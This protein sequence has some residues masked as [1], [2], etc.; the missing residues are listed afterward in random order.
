MTE[1]E[2][3]DCGARVTAWEVSQRQGRG[4]VFA[5]S[6]VRSEVDAAFEYV[7]Q[8]VCAG[9]PACERGDTCPRCGNRSVMLP[10]IGGEF[11]AVPELGT[12]GGR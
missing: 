6:Y 8:V 1:T 12:R 5:R 2:C 9:A 3:G 10:D 11:V 7:S 4:E